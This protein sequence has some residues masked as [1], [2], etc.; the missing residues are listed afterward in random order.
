MQSVDLGQTSMPAR[1]SGAPDLGQV[2]YPVREMAPAVAFYRD[3]VGLP[4]KFQ[5]GDRWA[6]F[7]AGAA[8]FALAPGATG[9]GATAAF[10][11]ADLAAFAAALA[12]RS[13]AP[14]PAIARGAHEL[15]LTLADPSGNAVVFYQSLPQPAG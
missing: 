11:V 4:L 8:T 15:T 5:D 14:V 3:V 10:R 7:R 12:A 6:A 13:P 9:G 2:I 1:G